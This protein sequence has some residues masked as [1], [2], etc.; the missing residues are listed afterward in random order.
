M[1]IL[2]LTGWRA[3]PGG[4]KPTLLARH[5][6]EVIDPKLPDDDFDEAVRVAQAEFDRHQPDV[7]V[8]LSRGGAVAVNLSSGFSRL[9]LLC[10]GWK[11]WGKA[12]TVKPSTVILHSRADSI[13]PFS[14][15]EELA[16]DSGLPAS[17]LIEVGTDHWLADP[18]SLR[19][20]LEACEGSTQARQGTT[21]PAGA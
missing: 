16:R 15:S 13:V 11:K 7:V 4:A 18:D 19:R 6:H 5:G 1:K 2:F 3:S 10:P 20:M 12:R 9:V 8:G 17:A 21:R 14:D